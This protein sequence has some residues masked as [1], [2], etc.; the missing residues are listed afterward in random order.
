MAHTFYSS[1]CEAGAGGS[2]VHGHPQL[3]N[4]FEA[5]LGCM[6]LYIQKVK[7]NKNYCCFIK[8]KKWTTRTRGRKMPLCQGMKTSQAVSIWQP[9]HSPEIWVYEIRLARMNAPV[10][11]WIRGYITQS[12][13]PAPFQEIHVVV[14]QSA[15]VL[16][17]MVSTAKPTLNVQ[18]FFS[19]NPSYACS[20][21]NS[22]TLGSV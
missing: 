7:Y 10:G 12:T 18:F 6:R 3:Y 1:P 22:V 15:S 20:N 4:E 14:A 19:I 2:G 16:K 9:V 11:F 5:S 8:I 13:G 21:L 17:R